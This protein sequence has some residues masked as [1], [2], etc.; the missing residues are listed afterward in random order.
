L[1]AD[2]LKLQTAIVSEVM[3]VQ[4]LLQVNTIPGKEREKKKKETKEKR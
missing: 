1:Y 4:P 2:K 3:P